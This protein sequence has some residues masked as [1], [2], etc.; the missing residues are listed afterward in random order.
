MS[1]ITYTKV[2][3]GGL[4]KRVLLYL[5]TLAGTKR[6]S[7]GFLTG[8]SLGFGRLVIET[9]QQCNNN[10]A[11][12]SSSAQFSYAQHKCFKKEKKK[13]KKS[14]NVRISKSHPTVITY[15][16]PQKTDLSKCIMD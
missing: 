14:E 7:S 9:S 11:T 15:H 16:P 3:G 1:L 12:W 4:K 10:N 5:G 13:K 8:S 2:L 6:S